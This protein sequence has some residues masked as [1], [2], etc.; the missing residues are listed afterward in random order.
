MSPTPP[1]KT[2][3]ASAAHSTIIP[4]DI[5]RLGRG[6]GGVGGTTGE[7]GGIYDGYAIGGYSEDEADDEENEDGSADARDADSEDEAACGINAPHRGQNDT[8]DETCKPQF[9]QNFI[10]AP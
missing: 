3:T 5:P 4:L 8:S 7:G 2:I 6:G 9:V 1:S 10:T